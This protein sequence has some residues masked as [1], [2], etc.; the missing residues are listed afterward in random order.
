MP[1]YENTCLRDLRSSPTQIG[2]QPQKMARGLKFRIIDVDELY[3][4]C[5]RAADLRLCFRIIKNTDFLMKRLIC[6]LQSLS[7]IRYHPKSSSF[8]TFVPEAF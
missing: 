7:L 4:L 3:Y 8:T 5:D 2:I 1:R 6:Q